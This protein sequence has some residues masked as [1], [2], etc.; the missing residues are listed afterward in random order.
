MAHPVTA[1]GT[2]RDMGELPAQ[3]YEQLR[4]L[5]RARLASERPGHTL[6]PTALVHEAWL[7]LAQH[8]RGAQTS[9][10]GFFAAAAEAMRQILVDYARTRRRVK[11]GG[12]AA[13]QAVEVDELPAK[14]P[15][16]FN[17]TPEEILALDGAIRRLERE[18]PMAAKVV[19]M[20][21]FAGLSVP[22]TAEALD[23][24][25]RTVKREWQFARAWLY[26]ELDE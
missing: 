20:R 7:K 23:V 2:I 5:A 21:F 8:E 18:D 19:T 12:G 6:Q 11:R 15:A 16:T 17:G 3:V 1:T 22:E 10:A 9:R 25:E 4:G 14:L 26:R 13:R 24:S